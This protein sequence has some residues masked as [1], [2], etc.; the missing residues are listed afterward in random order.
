MVLVVSI[1][2][3]ILPIISLSI[4]LIAM[5]IS[6]KKHRY[7]IF[8]ALSLAAIAYLYVPGSSDDLYRNQL[9]AYKLF[10]SSDLYIFNRLLTD[11]EKIPIIINMLVLKMGKIN[12]LQFIVTFISYFNILYVVNRE[13]KKENGTIS[14]VIVL[15]FTIASFS[16][17]SIVSNLWFMLASTLLSIGIIK[18]LKDD[19][20]VVG[21]VFMILSLF[22]HSS[23]I[24]PIGMFIIYIINGK[25]FS[26]K[27]SI[28]LFV[29]FS[30]IGVILNYL[31]LK[32]NNIFIN[33]LYRYY[34]PY[35]EDTSFANS[36]HSTRL[37]ILYMVKLIP[38][39]LTFFY[40][41]G[42]KDDNVSNCSMHFALIV[43][44]LF[45]FSSFSVRFIPIVQ[46][47]GVGMIYKLFNDKTKSLYKVF[48]HLIVIAITIVWIFLN[49]YQI[50]KMNF[51]NFDNGLVSNIVNIIE[52]R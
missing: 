33:E 13:Y 11:I 50:K 20:I 27:L 28:A 4:S 17:L 36:M 5:V 10:Y 7:A 21:V 14:Y 3:F 24:F 42:F 31:V 22:T 43:A 2:Y 35:F 49:Y 34:I 48:L 1:L 6:K 47:L 41:G 40:Y 16:Y 44:S 38:Y 39:I 26:F 23:M 18:Y 51:Y 37:M 30:M 46:L 52:S 29:I 25:K 15:L 9:V 19:N 12:L 45:V 8:V 32:Y